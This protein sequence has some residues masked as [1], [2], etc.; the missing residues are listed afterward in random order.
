[1]SYWHD[2]S[3]G[4]HYVETPDCPLH[5]AVTHFTEFW[6]N[7]G[8]DIT[9]ELQRVTWDS[10]VVTIRT[11]DGHITA[12]FRDT[13]SNKCHSSVRAGMRVPRIEKETDLRLDQQEAD[14]MS[15]D[16]RLILDQEAAAQYAD[17]LILAAQ[18]AELDKLMTRIQTGLPIRI[19]YYDADPPISVTEIRTP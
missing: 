2:I 11:E 15:D 5:E 6:I 14:C 17:K 12:F 19:C 13:Q 8:R 18:Q 16:E 10:I 4:F 1:M 9:R 7:V 3:H